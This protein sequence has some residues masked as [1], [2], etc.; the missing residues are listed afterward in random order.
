MRT[1]F[2]AIVLAMIFV[3]SFG[4]A[5]GENEKGNVEADGLSEAPSET[6][7]IA[8]EK[9]RLGPNEAV[10]AYLDAVRQGDELTMNYLLT[11]VARKK[12]EEQDIAV[13]PPG[14]ESAQFEVDEIVYLD[15]AKT[16]A[17]VGSRWTEEGASGLP[18]SYRLIWVA[19]K[20]QA[21]WRVAGMMVTVFDDRPPV[22]FNFEDPASVIRQ[23]E[24]IRAEVA[25]RN[26]T[27]YR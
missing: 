10:K 1:F 11:K 24:A 21:G 3:P 23:Q 26:G 18:E 5:N 25:R 14:N 6:A 19:R 27:V 16:I 12:N 15:D 13:A 20:E 2:S 22:E 7:K 4:C 8:G 9:A 17:H